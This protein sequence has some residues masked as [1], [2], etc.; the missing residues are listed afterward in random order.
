ML[1][2]LLLFISIV[3]ANLPWLNKSFLIFKGLK[4]A[5]IIASYLH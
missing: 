4:E 5:Q 1:I 3:A 2:W